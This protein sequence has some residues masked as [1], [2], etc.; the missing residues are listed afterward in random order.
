MSVIKSKRSVSGVQ[1]LDTA[2]DLDLFT[3]RTCV[4]YIPKRYTFYITQPI[5]NIASNIHSCVKR[6]NSIFPATARDVEMRREQFIMANAELQNL[7]SKINLAYEMFPIADKVILKWLDLVNKELSLIKTVIK[8]DE[9]RYK[10][11]V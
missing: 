11:I 5:I 3:M 6:G 8:K 2:K 7:I 9:E 10:A 1:F 4:K